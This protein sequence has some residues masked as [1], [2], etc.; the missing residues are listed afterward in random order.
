MD[1]PWKNWKFSPAD[2]AERGHWDEYMAAYEEAIVA[3]A[4]ERAPWFVVPA[5]NKWFT[6]LVVV[7]AMIEALEDLELK[8]PVLAPQDEA[9]LADA[10]RLLK[11]EKD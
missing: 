10:R 7:Q 4:D 11:E 5:D 6:W 2:V 1:Q 3:T 9:R 8:P